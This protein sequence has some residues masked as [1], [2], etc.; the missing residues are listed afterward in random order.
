MSDCEVVE[1]QHQAG[2]TLG[3]IDGLSRFRDTQFD[4]SAN[5]LPMLGNIDPFYLLCDPRRS[6]RGGLSSHLSCLH[7]LMPCWYNYYHDPNCLH[8]RSPVIS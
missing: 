7:S 3:D 1:V 4:R 2:V 5:L 6:I 8:L